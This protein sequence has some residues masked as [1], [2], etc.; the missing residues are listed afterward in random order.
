MI[1][2]LSKETE[3]GKS[4]ISASKKHLHNDCFIHWH[5][6]YEIEY[7]MRGHGSCELNGERYDHHPGMLFF[8]TPLDCHS[9]DCHDSDIINVMFTEQFVDSGYLEPFLRYSAP[10]AIPINEE[11]LPFFN[12]LLCEM[13]ESNENP[14][15]S[16]ALLTCLLIK[17]RNMLP[18]QTSSPLSNAVSKMHLYALT[19][20]QNKITLDDAADHV[21][22]TPSY[23]SALFKKEMGVNFKTFL[24]SLRFDLAR[25]LL[26]S[27]DQ[28]VSKIC[29]TSGFEDVPNF[30]K[31]FKMHY[32]VTPTELRKSG[33]TP[34]TAK[35]S[36]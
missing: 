24:D 16:A 31:R 33:R 18:E 14:E 32:G 35:K 19:N 12:Q 2:K 25:K 5:E 20:F 26:I 10:K 11:D 13:A 9:L 27:S 34:P 6:F 21:G 8:M 29:E 30:I 15:Y 22:L 28:T 1:K 4:N 23:A 7:V 3:L 17:L 36:S